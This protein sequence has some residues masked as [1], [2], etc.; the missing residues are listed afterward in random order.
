VGV[1][2]V[3]QT[4]EMELSRGRELLQVEISNVTLSQGRCKFPTVATRSGTCI[5]RHRCRG[6]PRR[7]VID[8]RTLHPNGV[9]DE[10]DMA[11][12]KISRES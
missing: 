1:S 10:K 6:R 3:S 4:E 12:I 9:E 5:L 7:E 8:I 11:V 2:S